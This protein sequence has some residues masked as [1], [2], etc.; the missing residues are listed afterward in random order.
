MKDLHTL[1]TDADPVTAKPELSPEEALA[2]R[3][4]VL[5]AARTDRPARDP[6]SGAL[7]VAAVVILTIAAGVALGR[8]LPGGT[9]SAG[10]SAHALA[11]PSERRQVR[12]ATPGGTRIIWTL[13]PEFELRGS[14]P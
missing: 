7:P 1:L 3:R 14:T 8:K 5:S 10:I 9:E 12:F 2:M 6:W 4:L 13:D 11:A